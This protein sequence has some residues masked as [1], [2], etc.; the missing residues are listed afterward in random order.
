MI[1]YTHAKTPTDLAGILRL[2][3]ANLRPGLSAEEIQSQGFVTVDHTEEQMAMLNAI[4]PHII[5]KVEDEVVAYLLAMTSA[6]K[7]DISVLEPLFE[8]FDGIQYRGKSIADY[9][10]LVVGQVCVS[11]AYRGQGVLDQC[12][13]AYREFYD[14]KY[15]FAIT[16][17]AL[18]NPRSLNAHR[19]VG[20]EVIH[21]YTDPKSGV[22]WAVVVWDWQNP[23]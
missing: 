3:K 5:A 13:A 16:E 20:F 23:A 10:Y 8:L 4:E 2:Q 1:Y 14:Q 7:K 6:S 11:K 21:T 18:D 19:R 17:I 12:Y 15:A 22:E 9:P